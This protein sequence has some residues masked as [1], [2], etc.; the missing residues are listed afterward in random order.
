MG[1]LARERFELA[2][3]TYGGDA[4]ELHVVKL[5]EESAGLLLRPPHGQK[6]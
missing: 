3:K 4:A 1:G 2:R 6:P 5:I